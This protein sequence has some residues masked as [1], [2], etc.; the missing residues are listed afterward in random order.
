[1]KNHTQQASDRNEAASAAP[2]PCV[3][4]PKEG[5]SGPRTSQRQ[6]DAARR[7]SRGLR[8]K[9]RAEIPVAYSECGGRRGVLLPIRLRMWP[10]EKAE[11]NENPKRKMKRAKICK[12]RKTDERRKASGGPSV[13][14]ARHGSGASRL[15][16]VTVAALVPANPKPKLSTS[17]AGTARRRGLAA[18][19]RDGGGQKRA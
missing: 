3:A 16:P 5:T 19:T 10:T 4:R 2:R 14:P 1:M 7:C 13:G 8:N 17:P 9:A 12:R 6:V 15:R 18:P 11:K